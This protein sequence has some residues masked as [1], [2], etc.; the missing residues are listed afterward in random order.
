MHTEK[1]IRLQSRLSKLRKVYLPRVFSSTG[2]YSDSVYEKVRAYKVLAHAEMEYYFE[3]VALAIAK[4]AHTKWKT[5]NKTSTPLVSMVAYYEGRVWAPPNAHDGNNADKD[6][7]W[8]I[9]EAYT[10]YNNSVRANNHGIKEKNILSIFLPIG[11]K[12][13]DIDESM[14]LA[15]DN[16]GSERGT[17]AHST[18]ASTLTT[19]N[20][21]L[22]SVD[23]LM[24]YID[25][26]DQ[27]LAEYK[28]SVR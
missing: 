12:I 23:D 11:I 25:A 3:E 16:F 24:T 27:C 8:R 7:D 17:I 19:P 28:K 5:E 21:A 22:A 2:S 15:L 10:H 13:S 6:L 26:F 4:K 14:L 18:R 1:Y 9:D 20:D